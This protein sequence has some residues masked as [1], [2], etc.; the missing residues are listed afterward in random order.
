MTGQ[1]PNNQCELTKHDTG[2]RRV[3][4]HFTPSWFSVTMGTGIVSILLNTLPYNGQ[5]LY[6]ISVVLFAFN[7]LLFTIGCIITFLRYTLY[8]EIF[9]AMIKHP[10][11]SMFIGTFPMG[12]A[13]IINMFC[14]VCVPAWGDWTRNFAWGLWIFDAIFSVITALSLPFLLMAHGTEMQ[15]SSMTAVWLLPIVSC[16]VAA[17][18]GAIVA[19]VLPNP[20]HALWT[21]LVSYVLWGIG[22]PLALMVMV[23]YLQRLTLHKLPP[24]AVIVSVFLPLGPLGQGGFGIMKL[25]QAAQE[26]FPKTQTLEAAS[27]PIFYTLGFMVALILWS[28][29]LVWLFFALASIAR[30][31]SFPFNIGWWGFTFPLGVY[32]TSTCQMGKELPSEFFRVLGTILSLCV[33]VLWIVVSIGTLRGVVSGRLFFAPCLGD[34]K[35]R[36]DENKDGTKAA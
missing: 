5:W 25:G 26:I 18:S 34:L 33:V 12:F 29:G 21:V 17:S 24:K 11:Q 35:A 9:F 4:R 19:D 14:F 7:V 30:S 23:I 16:I 20:Q 27:G 3:V 6:W 31:K 8:P 28:F 32:A 1:D 36:E 2:W 10:V 13:T 15:L 22:L